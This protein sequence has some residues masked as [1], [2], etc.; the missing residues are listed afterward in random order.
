MLS[1]V[2]FENQ[3]PQKAASYTYGTYYFGGN[4]LA[5]LSAIQFVECAFT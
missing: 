4:D 1:I 3:D 2:Q 5:K